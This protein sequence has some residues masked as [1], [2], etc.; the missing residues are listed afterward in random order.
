VGLLNRSNFLKVKR[1]DD[2]HCRCELELCG[3]ENAAAA[4]GRVENV[5]SQVALVAAAWSLAL[6]LSRNSVRLAVTCPYHGCQGLL[7]DLSHC[8]V[9]YSIQ[10]SSPCTMSLQLSGCFAFPTRNKN[11]PGQ[12]SK[13]TFKFILD[14]MDNDCQCTNTRLWRC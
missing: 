6:G 1:G 5:Q 10:L 2:R 3:S 11:L 8:S 9:L 4:S 12:R 7:R 14:A 13:F